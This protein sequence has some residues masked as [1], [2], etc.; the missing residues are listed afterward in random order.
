MGI[1]WR[2]F[3]VRIFKQGAMGFVQRAA[4]VASNPGLASPEAGYG[5]GKAERLRSHA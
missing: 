5:R 1:V 4:D 2:N 3:G